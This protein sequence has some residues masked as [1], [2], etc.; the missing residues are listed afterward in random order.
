ML[1]VVIRDEF[2]SP[3]EF[4]AY[5]NKP[6]KVP[7]SIFIGLF[8][9][10]TIF[11]IFQTLKTMV[12]KRYASK[13]KRVLWI[14]LPFVLGGIIETIGYMS[15]IFSSSNFTELWTDIIQI[16][17]VLVAPP[18]YAATIYMSLGRLIEFIEC[19]KYSIVPLKY[20][21]KIFVIGDLLS[22]IL[23]GAGGVMWSWDIYAFTG[24]ILIVTGLAVQIV[25]LGMFIVVESIFNYRIH[26][27]PSEYALITRNVP[28][29]FN[30]WNSILN[31]LLTC[32]ILILIRS[33]FRLIEYCQGT[34]G[35]LLSNEVFLYCFDGVLM[36]LNMLIFISQDIGNY[37]VSFR[38]L[39]TDDADNTE[40]N[41][42]EI[43]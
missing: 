29:R 43:S 28:S 14:M 1:N 37:C 11:Q 36:F 17:L 30:N 9:L 39:M 6:S 42:I 16:I 4:Q 2:L 15:R 41:T 19:Q 26:K 31:T 18:L 5:N 33:I 10:A 27:N 20:M 34:N 40:H 32:S 21:T 7:A 25:F 13:E 38:A 23:Q 24:K 3:E 8:A 35:Y 22:F 12:S